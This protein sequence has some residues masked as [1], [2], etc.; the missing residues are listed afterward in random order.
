M[1]NLPRVWCA[2]ALVLLA[3]CAQVAP[4][5]TD[6]SVAVYV[7]QFELV[8]RLSVRDGQRGE[9][10]TLRWQ[11]TATSQQ[12]ILLSPLGQTVAQLTQQAGGKAVLL[13]NNETRTAR[14]LTDLTRDALGTAVPIDELAHWVQGHAQAPG[15]SRA[16][17]APATQF[18]H[19]G[20]RVEIENYRSVDGSAV[21]GRVVAI[22]GD[23]V[24][25]LVID[26]WKALR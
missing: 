12:I 2:A 19:A 22:K 16:A 1:R 23:I 14:T 17:V 9:F 11:R 3:G 20:W 26:E 7:P 5:D 8:G 18:Q 21:A 4:R 13:A 6:M 10:G 25:K 24:V 15:S